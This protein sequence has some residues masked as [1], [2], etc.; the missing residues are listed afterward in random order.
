[1]NKEFLIKDSVTTLAVAI[2]E[3]QLIPN[4]VHLANCVDRLN[5]AL[6]PLWIKNQDDMLC[7]L[8]VCLQIEPTE[9]NLIAKCSKAL[10]KIIPKLGSC[11]EKH[12]KNLISW[13]MSSILHVNDLEHDSTEQFNDILNLYT[14]TLQY[15]GSQNSNKNNEVICHVMSVFSSLLN[16][17]KSGKMAEN[18]TLKLACVQFLNATV[19]Y[20]KDYPSVDCVGT[21]IINLLEQSINQ[22]YNLQPCQKLDILKYSLKILLQL[23]DESK[24]WTNNNFNKLLSLVLLYLRYGLISDYSKLPNDLQPSPIVQWETPSRLDI[25]QTTNLTNKHRRKKKIITESKNKVPKLFTFTADDEALMNVRDSDFSEDEPSMTGTCGRGA[26]DVRLLAAQTMKK[27]FTTVEKKT[28]L[29]YLYTIIDGPMDIQNCLQPNVGTFTRDPCSKV[30][31]TVITAIT[32]IFNGSK[33]FFAQAQYREK[34]GAFTTWSETLADYIISMHDTLLK[35]FE[36]ETLGVRL[37]LLHCFST[38]IT[39]T[40]YAKMNKNLL[41]SLLNVLLVFTKCEPC[42]NY[43]RIG[44]LR[45]LSSVFNNPELPDFEKDLLIKHRSDII[46]L[47]LYLFKETKTALEGDQ[48]APQMVLR[49]QCWQMLNSYCNHYD[50]LIEN[51]MIINIG[52]EDMKYTK[53]NLLR[54]NVLLCFKQMSAMSEGKHCDSARLEK[55]KF[56]FRKVAPQ[57]FEER[58]AMILSI[59]IESFSTIGSGLFSDLEDELVNPYCNDLHTFAVCTDVNIQ[60]A[61]IATLGTLIKY[62]KLLNQPRYVEQTIDDLLYVSSTNNIHSVQEKLAWTFNCLAEVLV[63]NWMSYEIEDLKLIALVKATLSTLDRKPCRAC[64]TRALGLFL[65]LIDN[66]SIAEAQARPLF[67]ESIEVLINIANGNDSMKNR[68]NSCNS[69]GII[70]QTNYLQKLPV[71]LQNDIFNTLSTLIVSCSNFKVR[72]VA[73]SSLMFDRRELYGVN[74]LKMWHRLFDAFENAQNLPHICEYKHK[75]KLMNQ[76][77]AS[78]CNL[79]RLLESSDIS[80]LADLFDSRLHLAREE[81]DKYY[82]SLDVTNCSI[83]LSTTHNNLQNL[84][85]QPRL[86]AKQIETVR[87]LLSIFNYR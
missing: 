73:C 6:N 64:G 58:N 11:E 2:A 66:T 70:Y 69:L 40:A 79:C 67:Q 45:C 1:M 22:N 61:A 85:K 54:K 33:I 46:N 17:I 14:C 39:N 48:N 84:L 27:L 80:N 74:Y 13:I 77:C 81:I 25:G 15:Y 53:Q 30:R 34:K 32:T 72:H 56:I 52:V 8:E 75:E 83:Q 26:W 5:N 49:R 57:V 78:F 19:S 29:G 43:L 50:S 36:C 12:V 65:S 23:V 62:D 87:H 60:S 18:T 21:F 68:W 59:L 76:L 7:L 41:G 31:A 82:N 51:R 35:D 71:I 4:T 9:I 3:H 24:L 16:E 42:E 28:L 44:V 47:C 20:L 63:D 10:V 55:W 37:V 38:M 86:T